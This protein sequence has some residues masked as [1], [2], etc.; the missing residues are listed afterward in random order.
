M[1]LIQGL[2]VL[3]FAASAAPAVTQEPAASPTSGVGAISGAVVDSIRG[4]L[5]ARAMVALEG[6]SRMT[7]TDS[8]GR[9]L[10]DSVPAG[11]H[12]LVL[13]DD[14]LDTLSLSVVSSPITVTRGDTVFVIMAIPSPETVISAKCGP[15]PFPMGRSALFGLVIDAETEQ[16]VAD[17]D[18][19]L[20]WSEVEASRDVGV[21]TI[22]RQRAAKAAQDGSFRI[23]GLPPDVAGELVAWSRTDTTAAVPFA[24]LGSPL[25]M[26]TL[27][28]PGRMAAADSSARGAGGIAAGSRLRAGRSAIAGTVTT[29]GGAPIS[30]ARISVQGAAPIAMTNERGEFT[31]SGLPAGSQTVLVRKLGYQPAEFGVNLSA[32]RPVEVEVELPE[33][34]PVLSTVVVRGQMDVALD[35]V[36][37]TRRR[38]VGM[39]RFMGLE[40][41][42]R[43]NAL[44]VTDLLAEFPMLQVVSTGGTSQ[45]VTGRQRGIGNN[46]VAFFVDGNI[47]MGEDSPVDY[48]HPQ[49][50]GAIE[51][52]SAATTPAEFSRTMNSCETVVIWSRHR[53]GMI[54]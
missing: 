48:L 50:I 15:G 4:G 33:F 51:V 32:T 30:D 24:M 34:V 36:G 35:R 25:A 11:P 8:I 40:D 29:L 3:A 39:G 26:R 22:P 31:L 37:F 21:R 23:C 54:R 20:A 10:L 28:F 27:A 47:W 19:V 45:T 12:R 38:Q 46:C 13:M 44:R 43:R 18:V 1:R 16:R 5:L 49:E 14:L 17:A 6:G 52:Y 9:F 7:L 2:T 41:I 53:L 42:E